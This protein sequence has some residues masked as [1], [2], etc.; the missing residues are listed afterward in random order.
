MESYSEIKFENN[1][2]LLSLPYFTGT[3][4][5]LAGQLRPKAIFKIKS[6]PS[7]FILIV[8]FSQSKYNNNFHHFNFTIDS[9]KPMGEMIEYLSTFSIHL[10]ILDSTGEPISVK[11]FPNP[12]ILS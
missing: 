6:H 8:Y 12:S 2:L 10:V 7:G 9:F 3:S 1:D 4:E 5:L 11:T